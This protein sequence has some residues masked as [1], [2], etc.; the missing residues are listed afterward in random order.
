MLSRQRA[1]DNSDEDKDNDKECDVETRKEMR[2]S[3]EPR[4]LQQDCLT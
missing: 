1:M 4:D 2:V 3:R